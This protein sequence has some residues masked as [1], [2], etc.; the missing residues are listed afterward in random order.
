M[1]KIEDML[2][3]FCHIFAGFVDSCRNL[4]VE[5]ADREIAFCKSF[6]DIHLLGASHVFLGAIWAF[7]GLRS[8]LVSL[9]VIPAAYISVL[10]SM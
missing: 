10:G 2:G 4:L 6:R 8:L 5:N 3:P 7:P 1:P 9:V